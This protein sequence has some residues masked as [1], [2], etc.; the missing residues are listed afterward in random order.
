M[1]TENAANRFDQTFF[2]IGAT[3]RTIARGRH[4]KWYLDCIRTGALIVV[5]VTMVSCTRRAP[6]VL[7][8][9]PTTSR[10]NGASISMAHEQAKEFYV[11]LTNASHTSKSVWDD[12]N[13]WGYQV[14]SFEVTTPDG[15]KSVISKR[16]QGFGKNGPSTFVI[17]PGEHQVYSIRLDD[18]WEVHPALPSN[19]EMPVSVQ[20][21]YDVQSSPEAAKYKVWVGRIE[22]KK[23][24]LNLRHW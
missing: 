18:E 22:S 10:N 6:F 12:W 5:F 16:P 17:P 9:V 2:Q 8:L 20:A 23:Y 24:Q 4:W 1:P 3:A 13:S 15:R 11:V 14:M 19:D 21:V 7:S